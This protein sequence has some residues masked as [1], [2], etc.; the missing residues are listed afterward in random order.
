MQ[1]L[2]ELLNKFCKCYAILGN[3][4]MTNVIVIFQACV[5]KSACMEANAYKKILAHAEEDISVNDV[6]TVSK[7]QVHNKSIFKLFLLK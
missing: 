5:V 3:C 4:V 2:T 7:S 1:V 6:N